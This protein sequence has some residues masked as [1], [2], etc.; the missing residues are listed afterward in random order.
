MRPRPLR[1]GA[2][3]AAVVLASAALSGGSLYMR[4][5][6]AL[7]EEVQASLRATASAAARFVDVPL[8]ATF[9]SPEQESSPEYERAVAPLRS[10]LEGHGQLA[11]IYTCVLR[12]DR[13]Y[14]VLDPTP[15]GDANHDGLE[16]KSHV[17]E[18]YPEASNELFQALREGRATNDAE[19]YRDR[20]GVFMS[21][22]AP[23]FDSQGR[24]AGVAGVD[25]EASEYVKHMAGIRHAGLLG[26][27]VALPVSL[28]VGVVVWRLRRRAAKAQASLHALLDDLRAARVAAEAAAQAKAEFLANMSHE[29]RT[30]LNGMIGM[31]GLL[32]DTDLSAEQEDYARTAL[33]SGR[34]LLD[35][36]NDILDFSR[37]EARR[38]DL[39]NARFDPREVVEDVVELL[40]HR[41]GDDVE[42]CCL[43]DG[44]VPAEVVGDAARLRQVLTILV[45]NALKFTERGEIVIGMEVDVQEPG[46]TQLRFEV[47]DTGIGVDPARADRL[48]KSFSQADGSTTRRHGGTGLGLAIAKRLVELMG[49]SIGMR[50]APRIGSTFW[51]TVRLE[52]GWGRQDQRHGETGI[53]AGSSVLVVDDHPTTRLALER[54]LRAVR[55]LTDCVSSGSEA[56]R[57]LLAGA[58][59]GDL[60]ACVL[61]DADLPGM[62][63]LELARRVRAESRLAAL[64]VILLASARRAAALHE[65]AA[66]VDAACV[67]KPVSRARLLAALR[68]P[69]AAPDGAGE[70]SPPRRL[71]VLVADDDGT[72]QRMLTAHLERMG[73]R[74]DVVT[75]GREAVDAVARTA[76]DLVLMDC[77]MPGM[78]GLEATAE[79]RRTERDR[80]TR[81]LALTAD[82]APGM[83]ERC[84]AAGFDGWLLKPVSPEDLR[85]AIL[86]MTSPGPEVGLSRAS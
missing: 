66:E 18:E 30:P 20:W 58:D 28:L 31:T 61:I 51:F 67:A 21:G 72:N 65:V 39:E 3:A 33:A 56:L 82:G 29:L 19:P 16:D 37:I 52:G 84:M 17:L 40:A 14:F 47:R 86:A 73:W 26:A 53:P 32:L 10:I 74:A 49:G 79:I 5:V 2:L 6:T 50:S 69:S 15:P 38:V 78:D 45:G 24:I 62:G 27:A 81:I 83:R 36:I 64:P 77:R 44:D 13:V 22:Y 80:R 71:R 8:H 25:L 43:V 41:A 42:L 12:G 34:S 4:A 55:L 1:E 48:F 63:G 23:F 35:I 59:F 70:A 46:S 76:Y 9:T 68:A 11:F 57:R 7:R 54:E 85:T 75:N 60:P